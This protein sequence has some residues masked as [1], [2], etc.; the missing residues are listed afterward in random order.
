MASSTTQSLWTVTEI[1]VESPT[2]KTFRF[3]PPNRKAWFKF[4]AG[5]YADIT[6]M[7][8]GQ[9]VNRPYS[10]SSAS[11]QRGTFDLSIKREP[12]GYVSKYMHDYVKVGDQLGVASPFGEFYFGGKGAK[13]IVLL[14]A[15]VGVTPLMSMI[16]S[17]KAKK[18]SGKVKAIF[19]FRSVEDTLYVHE[20]NSLAANWPNLDVVFCYTGAG[21]DVSA[22]PAN[23]CTLE[24]GRV[25]PDLVENHV[26][27]LT[28]H[29]YY[30]CGPDQMMEDLK[31]GLI[32][33]GVPESKFHME[34]FNAPE[35]DLSKGGE[36]EI[37]FKKSDVTAT[38]QFGETILLTAERVGVNIPSSCRTG[39]CMLCQSTLC[40]GVI[41]IHNADS[42]DDDD[43]ESGE[44]L[45]CQTYPRNNCHIDA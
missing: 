31:T 22:H 23:V 1:I 12:E 3:L 7:I 16:R 41:E 30:C 26:S 25:T 11:T 32:A 33:K 13:S 20:L 18:W 8:D 40:K 35:V 17:L 6:V 21:D 37:Y 2:V 27:D 14:G 5:Q 19:G 15:G 44:L 29:S 39:T 28:A 42:L 24:A 45:S 4:T 38:S 10:I 36:F 34:S 9:S 43:L